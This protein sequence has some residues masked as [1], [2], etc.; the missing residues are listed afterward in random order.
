VDLPWLMREFAETGRLSRIEE[1]SA[2]ISMP[3]VVRLSHQCDRV[4]SGRR[5]KDVK[6]VFNADGSPW[7]RFDLTSDPG[8]M[9]NLGS[10]AAD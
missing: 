7:L 9:R 2:K 8:E 1:A 6:E 3:S 10:S 5:S 4:W